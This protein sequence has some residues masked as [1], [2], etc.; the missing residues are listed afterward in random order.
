MRETAIL[1]VR[2]GHTAG[3]RGGDEVVM[4]GQVP[5]RLTAEGR[6]QAIALAEGLLRA[7]VAAI[8][9]SPLRRAADTAR[10]IARARGATVRYAVEL[11]E[12]DCG[13]VD[14]A[15]IGEV[16]RRFPEAWEASMRQDDDDFRWPEGE[17]YAEV[18]RRALAGMRWIATRHPGQRVIAVTH[19]GVISQ[20]VGYLAGTPAARWEC[21]RPGNCSVTE[22]AWANGQ[23]RVVRFDDRS[24]LEGAG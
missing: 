22:I 7:P 8:Y 19:A 20:I 12:Q 21:H 4:S 14:G 9:S 11:M 18:R 15:P 16:K 6:R 24:A 5:I 3:N 2:H 1:L 10:A 13:V 23:A 17:S